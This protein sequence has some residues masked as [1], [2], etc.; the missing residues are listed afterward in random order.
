[1]AN[2]DRQVVKL[3]A[4]EISRAIRKANEENNRTYVNNQIANSGSRIAQTTTGNINVSQV[5]NLVPYLAGVIAGASGN[6]ATDP[7]AQLIFSAISGI[8]DLCVENA[9]ITTAQI[10]DLYASYGEF[11]HL[12]ADRAEIGEL[13][14]EQIRADRPLEWEVLL[15]WLERAASEYYGFFVMGV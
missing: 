1:M 3:M 12:V 8:A 11:L 14:V 13:D 4:E 6:A 2:V 5:S 10:E 15:P 9:T 7:N